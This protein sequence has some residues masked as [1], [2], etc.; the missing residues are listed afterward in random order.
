MATELKRRGLTL[1]AGALIAAEKGDRQ[2]WADYAFARKW[3]TKVTV[4]SAVLAQT[5]RGSSPTIARML[6]GCL[7]TPLE[8]DEARRIGELLAASRTA[9][10]VDGAVVLGA[11]ARGDVIVTSDQDDIARLL[12][13]A[14]APKHPILVR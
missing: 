8:A 11:M 1:D 3:G 2:M 13:A 9:D 6:A 4:P 7:V 12:T 14:G 5:W 10:I